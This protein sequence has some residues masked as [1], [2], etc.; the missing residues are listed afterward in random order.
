MGNLAL[1]LYTAYR[2]APAEFR[3]LSR[4]LIQLHTTF[5]ELN[6]DL[7]DPRSTLLRSGQQRMERLEVL[8]QNCGDILEELQDMYDEYKKLETRGRK[9]SWKRMKLV[10]M[11]DLRGIHERLARNSRAIQLFM[12]KVNQ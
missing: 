1:H 12:T 4:E 6:N 11:E 7:K 2:A 9:L 5:E 10:I 3:E 8:R